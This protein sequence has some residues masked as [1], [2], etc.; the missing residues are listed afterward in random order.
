MIRYVL[1]A[2]LMLLTFSSAAAQDVPT[3]SPTR[4][5]MDE[6]PFEDREYDL[7]LPQR[8][9]DD[10]ALMP[11][12]FV[13][14]GASGSGPGTRQWLGFDDLAQAAGFAV[15]YPTGVANNWDFGGGIRT[16][17]GLILSDDVS[18]LV[19]LAEQLEAEY[20][21]DSARVYATGMSNGAQMAYYLACQ[22]P[23]TFAA[24]AGVAAPLSGATAARCAQ[25]SISVLMVHGTLDPIL[26]WQP[27]YTT[28]GQ[29]ISLGATGTLE[30]WAQRN[31][32]NV[33]D[34]AIVVEEIPDADPDDG[35]TIRHVALDDCADHTN[36]QFYGVIGGGH[37]WPGHP[38]DISIDLG[39][40]NMDIDATALILDWLQGLNA[41]ASDEAD[42]S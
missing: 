14:H 7:F 2:L 40:T 19:W 36:V 5:P 28:N 35:S 12:L 3:P 13:L 41:P 30:F 17:D 33:E 37:T 11:L 6:T 21:I 23:E 38:L 18:Y 10:D 9:A 4:P 42:A 25:S 15:V 27:Q 32:C 20:P 26:Y 29:V 34:D 1:L 8:D 22:A 39:P 16:A 24:V 31:R